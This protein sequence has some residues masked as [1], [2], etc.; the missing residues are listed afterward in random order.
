MKKTWPTIRK[1]KRPGT[2]EK[3]WL[4]DGRFNRGG[5]AFG[6]RHYA[7]TEEA[8]RELARQLRIQREQEGAASFGA[9]SADLEDLRRARETLN[10]ITAP[11]PA[12][13]NAAVVELV[14]ARKRLADF[15]ARDHETLADALAELRAARE[16]LAEIAPPAPA[17]IIEAVGELGEAREILAPHGKTLREAAEFMAAHLAAL[18]KLKSRTVRETVAELLAEKTSKRLSARYLGDLAVRLEVF[19][20]GRKE[21]IEKKGGRVWEVKEL[22]PFGDR[23]MNDIK[24]DEIEEWIS[25]LEVFQPGRSN[26]GK[27]LSATSRNNFRRCLGVLF[28]FA[29]SKAYC[30]GNPAAEVT[31]VKT[32]SDGVGILTVEQTKKLLANADAAI[33]PFLAIGAFAGLRRSEIERLNW[34]EVSLEEREIEIKA[35][36]TKS[37]RR[38]I[39]TISDNLAAW[40]RPYAKTSGPVLMLSPDAMRGAFERAREEA[41]IKT[42][43]SNA[44]RHGFAS[45]HYQEHKNAALLAAELGHTDSDLLFDHYRSLVKGPAA[46]AYWQIRPESDN[47]DNVIAMPAAVA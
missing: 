42:W 32:V 20:T 12:S 26:F 40:L 17:S 1:D 39:V 13:I 33:L 45:Y 29:A 44:L 25:G 11:A 46:K 14:A 43:P 34:S 22:R 5:H 9:S 18:E 10:T 8:A 47:A 23:M 36:N 3:A 30:S 24:S 37:A 4:V 28:S 2:G 27:P 41:G 15:A 6:K 16:K 21:S 19:A 7:D 35:R 31:K 38:R